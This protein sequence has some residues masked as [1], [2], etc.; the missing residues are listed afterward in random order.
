MA[1]KAPRVR[2]PDSWL[3]LGL[4]ED[5]NEA[6][7][8]A[9]EEMVSLMGEQYN[10]PRAQ[11]LALASLVVDLHVTQIA[12]RVHGVHAILRDSFLL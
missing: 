11:A 8:L 2:T 3:T 1:L 6:T 12:N 5:L 9:L 4:H 7:L 10:L